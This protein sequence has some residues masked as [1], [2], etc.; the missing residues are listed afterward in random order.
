MKTTKS[1]TGKQ[2]KVNQLSAKRLT[3]E[4]EAKVKGGTVPPIA[5]N[6]RPKPGEP[7]SE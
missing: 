5:G 1:K 2:V 6:R 4:Q 7:I 3:R